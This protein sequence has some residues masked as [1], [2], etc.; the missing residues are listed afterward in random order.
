MLL[1]YTICFCLRGEQVLM[2][3][4]SKPP[5][6]QR[7][8]GLGGRIEEGETPLVCVQREI[9]LEY[10][11]HYQQHILQHMMI[12]EFQTDDFEIQE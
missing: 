12:Y 2:L 10:R 3:Y 9:F 8:N 6:A 1:P 4:R 11:C 5:N 7:W